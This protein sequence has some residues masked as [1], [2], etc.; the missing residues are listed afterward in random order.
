M[1]IKFI[2]GIFPAFVVYADDIGK[3]ESTGGYAKGFY[4]KI[5]S[6]YKLDIG[7]LEH[8]LTHVR[9]WYRTLTFHSFLYLF[10]K[11]YRKVSE[12]EAYK[13]QLRFFINRER[14][15]KIFR[16]ALMTKYDLKL[17]IN[18]VNKLLY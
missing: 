11:W 7:L 4:I 5:K 13:N 9:Q 3:P 6:K 15:L 10:S 8:E 14:E 1:T 12:V 18:E 2:Y 17:T 16:N